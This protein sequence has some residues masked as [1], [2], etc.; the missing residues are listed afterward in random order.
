MEKKKTALP[1][2]GIL[3][4]DN[5]WV[6]AGP[7]GTRMLSD[8]G[9]TV[10][11]IESSKKRDNIRF[12]HTRLGVKNAFEEGGWVFQ[13]NNRDALGLQLN[14]KSEKGKAIYHKLV[15]IGDVVVSN[16]TPKAV[17][18]MGIDFESLSKINP[19]IVTINASGLGDYGCKKDTMIFAAAL[20]C[21]TGLS[22]TV[23]YEGEQ[24]FGLAVSTAD[25]IG[26]AMIAFSILEALEARDRTG[27][28]QFIDLSEAE[29]MLGVTGAT[30]LEW[31]YNQSQTGPVGDHQYYGWC[32]PH[33]A[34]PSAGPDQWIAIS[35][36]SDEEYRNL[37]KIAA[38]EVPEL[39]E[40]RFGTYE[41]RKANEKELDA[42]VSRFTAKHNNRVLT[43]KLQEA[44][45]SAAPVNRA[46]EMLADEHLNARGYWQPANLP[47]TDPRQ[48]DFLI[49]A[50]VPKTIP[51]EERH[52]RPAPTLGQDNEYILKEL[53]H[54]T[55][56]EI[57]EAQ[58]DGAF[59]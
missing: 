32:C 24:G 3:I 37:L 46:F 57:R 41:G 54:L 16:V 35:C 4:I 43:Q 36:G 9:A 40:E 18:S 29:N 21:I 45:V 19:R 47:V 17:R 20:N 23:G 25:N 27:E 5:S 28:G 48:P 50:D 15:E 14:M 26:G 2:E 12:D 8:L 53:L 6:I 44:G 52:F 34:Y 51:R 10:I 55:D 22:Y 30:L 13:E 59:I 58:E 33:N 31:G 49:S 7:H 42:L 38:G 39:Q 1:L 56:E 11:R